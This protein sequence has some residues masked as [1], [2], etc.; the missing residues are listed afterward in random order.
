MD[1]SA[2]Y[3]V[4]L[5]LHSNHKLIEING[6]FSRQEAHRWQTARRYHSIC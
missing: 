6:D 3:D 5:T 1:K 2:T 4:L